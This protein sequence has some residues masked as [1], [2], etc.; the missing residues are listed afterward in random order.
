MYVQCVHSLS[1]KKKWAHLETVRN[2]YWDSELLARKLRNICKRIV[3]SLSL[4]LLRSGYQAVPLASVVAAATA[5]RKN[6][7]WRLATKPAAA[8]ASAGMAARSARSTCSAQ[9]LCRLV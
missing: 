1:E 4:S 3:L 7:G 5:G 2:L 9:G 6:V 8:R